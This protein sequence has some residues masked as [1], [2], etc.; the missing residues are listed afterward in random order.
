[1]AAKVVKKFK[2]RENIAKCSVDA[3]WSRRS[4]INTRVPFWHSRLV[5]LANWH[6]V[7][8]ICKADQPAD[9]IV[10]IERSKIPEGYVITTSVTKKKI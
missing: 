1:M 5:S 8:S 7:E 6:E 2:L 3:H 9:L 4:S 10:T